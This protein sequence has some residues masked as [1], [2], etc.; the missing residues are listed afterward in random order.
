M[1]KTLKNRVSQI[2]A[3]EAVNAK[4]LSKTLN[5]MEA[6]TSCSITYGHRFT[7][8]RYL[9]TCYVFRCTNCGFQYNRLEDNLTAKESKLVVLVY[10]EDKTN[11]KENLEMKYRCTLC[12]RYDVGNPRTLSIDDPIADICSNCFLL[13][14]NLILKIKKKARKERNQK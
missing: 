3:R 11:K 8:V 12:Q 14:Q 1:R 4:M 13:F 10:S 9:G 2:E 5:K 6:H 7:L